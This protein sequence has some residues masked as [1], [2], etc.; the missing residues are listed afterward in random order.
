MN[1]IIISRIAVVA[2]EI[3]KNPRNLSVYTVVVGP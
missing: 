2:N 3:R 1:I